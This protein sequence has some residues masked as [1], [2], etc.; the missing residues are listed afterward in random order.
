MTANIPEITVFKDEVAANILETIGSCSGYIIWPPGQ[1][2][3]VQIQ[4]QSSEIQI[5]HAST[6]MHTTVWSDILLS[7]LIHYYLPL[8]ETECRTEAVGGD[9][10]SSLTS[11]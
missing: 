7:R 10:E 9:N 11:P 8:L 5:Q 2:S 3:C 6:V 1:G 4:L